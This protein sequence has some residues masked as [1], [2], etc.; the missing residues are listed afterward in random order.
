MHRWLCDS[1]VTSAATTN[2]TVKSPS[3]M[4]GMLLKPKLVGDNCYLSVIN[5]YK[6]PKEKMKMYEVAVNLIS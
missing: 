2:M 4:G 5:A 6:V 1:R 3:G